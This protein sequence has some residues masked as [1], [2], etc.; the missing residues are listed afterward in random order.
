MSVLVQ[1]ISGLYQ[2]NKNDLRQKSEETSFS[3]GATPQEENIS[4]KSPSYSL[5]A[6]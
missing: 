4:P 2:R 3:E 5:R 6:S 1:T